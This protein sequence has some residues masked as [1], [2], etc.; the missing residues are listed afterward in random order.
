[1]ALLVVVVV[2]LAWAARDQNASLKEHRRLLDTLT[3]RLDAKPKLATIDI[4]EQCARQAREQYRQAGWE[5]QALANFQNHYSATLS[6]CFMLIEST[7]AVFTSKVLMDAFE[8]RILGNYLWQ[9]DKGKKFWEV[10]PIQ[11]DVLLPS[12]ETA[13]CKSS[14][15]F[16]ELAKAYLEEHPAAKD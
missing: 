16:E 8:G 6:K 10:P 4:Q 5:K 15:E 11:C 2:A 7:N 12:G 3:T 9:V 13:L 1:M 14:M